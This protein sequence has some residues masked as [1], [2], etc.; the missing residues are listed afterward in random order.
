M[1]AELLIYQSIWAP[2]V[3][4]DPKLEITNT[5]LARLTLIDGVRNSV[6][7]E[8]LRVSAPLHRKEPFEWVLDIWS[9]WLLDAFQWR[10]LRHFSLKGGLREGPGLDG[11]ITDG[12]GTICNRG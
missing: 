2:T 6:I 8:Q 4:T 10:C 12:L 7:Y 9:G 11:G 1:K 3:G 5:S